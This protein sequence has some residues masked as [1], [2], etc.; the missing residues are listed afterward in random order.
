MSKK[1]IALLV[2]IIFIMVLVVD[3]LIGDFISARLATTSWA[4]KW[5]LFNP[6]G[7]IVVTNR[8]TVRVNTNNDLVD[9]AEN[10]KTKTATLIY[11]DGDDMVVSGSAV[12]WTSDGYYLTAKTA[13]ATG[14]KAYAVVTGAGDVYPVEA[15]YPDPASGLTILQTSARDLT[16]FSPADSRDLRVGQQVVMI[17]NSLSSGD[18]RFFTGFVKRLSSDIAG[19]Q[20]DSDLISRNLELSMLETVPAGSAVLNLSGRIIGVW[21]GSS[22]VPVDELRELVNNLFANNKTIVRPTF[23]FSYV[24]LNEVEAKALQTVPGAKLTEI[25]NGGIA[26]QR[27]L[28]VDD[29]ITEVDGQKLDDGFNFDNWLRQVK[30]NQVISLTVQRGANPLSILLTA[31]QLE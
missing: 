9:T 18:T 13:L 21:D 25:P 1:H 11:F 14:G 2:L 5:G 22:V 30:P 17:Q 4:R 3:L 7:P 29:V 26:A 19:V 28:R 12:N 8:E 16:V 27:G 15:A 24:M 23:G 20:A 6:Q 31:G 10:A